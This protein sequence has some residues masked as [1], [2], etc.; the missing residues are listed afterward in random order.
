MKFE[1]CIVLTLIALKDSIKVDD[2]TQNL[3]KGHCHQQ[4]NN[5]LSEYVFNNI[6][7]VPMKY[8]SDAVLRTHKGMKP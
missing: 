2:R 8:K 5:E 6:N 7:S 1:I 3:I 4:P